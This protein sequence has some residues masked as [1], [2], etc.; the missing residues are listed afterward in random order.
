MSL[1]DMYLVFNKLL[2]ARSSQEIVFFKMDKDE[3]DPHR[4]WKQFY[5]LPHKGFLFFIKGNIRIQIT[6][7][8]KIYFYLIDPET[9]LPNLENVMYNYMN[10][11]QTMFGKRVRFCVTYKTNMR[12]F[13][14]YRRKF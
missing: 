2:V 3:N 13:D 4:M 14:V 1:G 5:T 12:S 7:D 9:L 10:C 11:N 8:E 6:T